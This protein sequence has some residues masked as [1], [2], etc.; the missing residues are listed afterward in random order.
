MIIII[1]NS[2]HNF[3]R[4]LLL[5]VECMHLLLNSQSN[6]LL[7]RIAY[8]KWAFKHDESTKLGCFIRME[9]SQL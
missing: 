7:R 9:S 5:L 2:I 4:V 8:N 1:D 6:N 3:R